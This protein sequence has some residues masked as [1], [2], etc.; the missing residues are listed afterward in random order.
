MPVDSGKVAVHPNPI[1]RERGDSIVVV[2]LEDGHT[3]DLW[4]KG[5]SENTFEICCIPFFAYDIAPGDVVEAT[6]SNDGCHLFR[7]V[8]Q[9]A[10]RH[11]FRIWFGDVATGTVRYDALSEVTSALA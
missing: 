11:V 4:A 8:V 9:D 5:L 3:E 6:H 10:G 7:R 2:D 1:W